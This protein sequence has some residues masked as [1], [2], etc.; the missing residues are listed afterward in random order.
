MFNERHTTLPVW[1]FC[2]SALWTKNDHNV[3]HLIKQAA[4][5]FT[6]VWMFH[7]MSAQMVLLPTTTIPVSAAAHFKVWPFY[8]NSSPKHYFLW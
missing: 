7:T 5:S 8:S 3:P 4:G 1:E 2:S 6:A